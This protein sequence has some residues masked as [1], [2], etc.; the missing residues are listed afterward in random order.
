MNSHE[1]I[2]YKWGVDQ[3]PHDK[4]KC[5][6]SWVDDA[7]ATFSTKPAV[8]YVDA[9]SETT[10]TFQNLAKCSMEI[11]MNLVALGINKGDRVGV[12][13]QRTLETSILILALSRI[14]AAF[15]PIDANTS[16]EKAS[17]ILS[18]THCQAAICDDNFFKSASP[19]EGGQLDFEDVYQDSDHKLRSP[20]PTVS[21]L[22]TLSISYRLGLDA[23]IKS[24]PILHKSI[25]QMF[26]RYN[27]LGEISSA[28][29]YIQT[30]SPTMVE[31]YTDFW[32]P[33]ASGATV[34]MIS[35]DKILDTRFVSK[36]ISDKR[37][38]CVY[39]TS[40]ILGAWA[41]LDSTILCGLRFLQFPPE[42]SDANLIGNQYPHKYGIH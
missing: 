31:F 32:H 13:S 6:H 7:A 16:A 41:R 27:V 8:V 22:D 30:S 37:V 35:T 12:F 25:H 34:V 20:L 10:V 11:A 29:V 18:A 33:I 21:S 40:S 19:L 42:A 39:S 4:Y 28:D 17:Q 38:T 3:K 9:E 23:A 26:Q 5:L 1:N 36:V 2:F 24:V 14:G 15:V